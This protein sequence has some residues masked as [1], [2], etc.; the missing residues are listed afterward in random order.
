MPGQYLFR[1]F[2]PL[3]VI[4]LMLGLTLAYSIL[5]GPE[6]NSAEAI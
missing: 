4:S 2:G 5:Y 3:L 6:E 1:G